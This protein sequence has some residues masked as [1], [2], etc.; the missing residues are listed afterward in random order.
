[1]RG[2]LAQI[3]TRHRERSGIRAR[4]AGGGD[5]R[6][7]E[8]AVVVRQLGRVL[9][10]EPLVGV[11]GGPVHRARHQLRRVP[12]PRARFF[13]PR[14]HFV[15]EVGQRGEELLVVEVPKP[16][17]LNKLTK[18]LLLRREARADDDAAGRR[19]YRIVV[20]AAAA[21]RESRQIS[22]SERRDPRHLLLRRRPRHIHQ[23]AHAAQT[24]HRVA[25]GRVEGEEPRAERSLVD[26]L[27]VVRSRVSS[28]QRSDGVDGARSVRDG[29]NLA[30]GEERRERG[31]ARWHRA[32]GVRRRGRGELPAEPTDQPDRRGA[33]YGFIFIR[34]DVFGAL[35]VLR[36]EPQLLIP[37]RP[38]VDEPRQ[39]E[40][41]LLAREPVGG[42][43]QPEEDGVRPRPGAV[44]A[45]LLP[46]VVF[47][48]R[49]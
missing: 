2:E 13:P 35:A 14:Q 39:A 45:F 47:L 18:R 11:R 17:V 49:R 5:E 31:D 42:G 27:N 16:Q 22:Q 29:P 28:E 25:R 9:P 46:V 43:E 26:L 34:H 36:S 6:P 33:G 1:M 23:P 32:C 19:R 3:V 38:L 15:L 44:V 21:A 37:R 10:P 20:V 8:P 7:Q 4:V 12:V 48:L 40:H 24:R 41:R 30:D